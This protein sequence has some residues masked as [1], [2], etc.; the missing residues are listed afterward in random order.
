RYGFEKA[1]LERVVAVAVPENTGSWR[2]MEK[3]GM[4]YEKT[5]E[6]YGEPCLF[7]AVSREEFLRRFPAK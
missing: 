6:H 2:I 1:G 7:Y 5:A 3:C 4:R